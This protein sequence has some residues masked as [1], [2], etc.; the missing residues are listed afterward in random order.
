MSADDFMRDLHNLADDDATGVIDDMTK[1]TQETPDDPVDAEIMESCHVQVRVWKSGPR[2]PDGR[3]GDILLEDLTAPME[4]ARWLASPQCS[5]RTGP[6]RRVYIYIDDHLVSNA[7]A[8]PI[9]E[10]D[11]PIREQVP[12]TH[13]PDG[14]AALQAY[15]A[16]LETQA[17]LAERT[18]EATL[19][20]YQAQ[21][22]QA[23]IFRDK[24]VSTCYAQ[25]EEARLRLAR[26]LR[27]EDLE[28]EAL[29]KRRAVINDQRQDMAGD[30]VS[31]SEALETLKEAAAEPSKEEVGEGFVSK[32]KETIA[33]VQ[34][35]T[36]QEVIGKLM[37]MYFEHKAKT[38]KT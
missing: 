5:K 24:E 15:Q 9:A 13:R 6:R 2:G 25:V 7:D 27:R 18:L 3:P 12:A 17:A 20:A 16:R 38:S 23:R 26:E 30:L 35:E 37:N 36:T 29:A 22:E 8:L 32:V 4:V 21:I 33:L 31:F 14:F 34:D 1:V 11:D 19:Q 10:E 28:L